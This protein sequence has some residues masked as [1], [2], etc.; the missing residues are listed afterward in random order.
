VLGRPKVDSVEVKFIADANTL[1]ANVLA[2]GV[3]IT[4]PASLSIEQALSVREQ[5]R[6]GTMVP[7]IQGWTIMYPQHNRPNPPAIGDPQFRRAL[8]HAI[9]RQQMSDSLTAGFGP[10]AHS[11]IPPDHP[12]YRFVESSIVRYDYDP[13]RATQLIAGMG[14]TAGGDGV[15]RDS[16]SEPL[17][18]KLQTTTNDTN[19]KASFATAD[20]FQRIGL[21]AEVKVIPPSMVGVWR[22]RYAYPGL[23]LTGQ[24]DGVRGI[25]NL[26]HSSGAPLPERNYMAPLAPS[27]RGA[28]VN[29]EYDAL[30]D[31]YLTT[32]PVSE[33]M[34][35]L[36]Q[37]I[38]WQSDQQL[39]IPLFY[40]ARG[41]VVANRLRSTT[42]GTNW[43]AH[44]WELV[45]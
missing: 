4:T 7:R 38:H 1:I 6:G 23:D 8:T 22:E 2:G 25:K 39:V 30:M 35:L 21:Q 33:R 15:Y 13:R 11:I 36:A 40:T 17:V 19:Q 18:M 24:S 10:V 44:E 12:E 14:L 43:N 28:Y 34:R 27:N 31:R 16:A 41:I 26:L 42:P 37:L 20:F 5:W 32:I 3:D 29:P 9:D 45:R